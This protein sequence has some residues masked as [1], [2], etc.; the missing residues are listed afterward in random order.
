ME[1]ENFNDSHTQYLT[2]QE[3]A[4][5]FRVTANTVKN[6]RNA[7][8]LDHFQVPCSTRVLYPTKSVNRFQEQYCKKAVVN[9]DRGQKEIKKS[10]EY[11]ID[12]NRIKNEWRLE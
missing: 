6:W 11:D 7:G 8:L 10:E 1:I 2:Q 4:D 5:L 12:S 9:T 3:V